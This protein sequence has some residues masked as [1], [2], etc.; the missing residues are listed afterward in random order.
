MKNYIAILIALI[1]FFRVSGQPAGDTVRAVY[2]DEY[3][4]KWF[5]TNMGLLRFDGTNW[6]AYNTRPS[7]PGI[8][9]SLA[10][11]QD[12]DGF[13]LWIGTDNGIAA[14]EYN[15]EGI[16]GAVRYD[17]VNSALGSNRV[18]DIVLDSSG[19]RYFA[20]PEGMAVFEN[21]QWTWLEKGWGPSESGIP[22]YELLSLGAKN[23]TVYVGAMNRGAG[24]VINE[25]DG[26]SGAS[27]YEQPWTGIAGNTI[28]SIFTDHDGYQWFGT[29]EGVSCHTHQDGDKGW[30]LYLSTT[31]GLADDEVN[32]IFQ[33]SGDEFW[34]GTSEGISKFNKNT[35]QFTNYTMENGLADNMVFDIAQGPDNIL[36][37]ATA[38]GVASF[39]G[40]DFVSIKT[41][42]HAVDFKDIIASVSRLP[43]NDHNPLRVYPV[44]S[45]THLYIHYFSGEPQTLA[46]DI[47]DTSGKR[48]RE[49]YNGNNNENEIKIRW[50]LQNSNDSKVPPGTYFIR[51]KTGDRTY[52]RKAI[53]LNY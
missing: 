48:I 34:M 8:V 43:A 7:T 2:V 21:D 44:P 30:G 6:Q 22:N 47:F 13:I 9:N 33:D 24:R 50:D 37:F 15:D 40:T 52:I 4:V 10:A 25:I 53:I 19:T 17:S 18:V 1:A 41:S 42:S 16:T 29:T 12:D 14:A 32:D 38:G 51:L 46:I 39:E 27:Y 3:N 31:D 11:E 20:T 49:L 36:W 45:A 5:G 28:K 35:M 26:F 23:D